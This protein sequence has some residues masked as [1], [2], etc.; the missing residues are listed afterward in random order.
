MSENEIEE[1]E[2]LKTRVSLLER[3]VNNLETSLDK[4]MKSTELM[5]TSVIGILDSLPPG[6]DPRDYA[7]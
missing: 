1:Y 2:Y 4:L 7:Q 6:E 5:T 3:Q